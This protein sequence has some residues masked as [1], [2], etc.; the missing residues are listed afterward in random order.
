MHY[1][2][3][4]IHG[5]FYTLQKLLD[6]IRTKDS[7]PQLIFIGDY[8]DRGLH[9]KQV[10]DL[11]I[12]LQTEGAVCLRGNHDDVVDWL[13]NRKCTS[14]LAELMPPG[15]PLNLVTVGSWWLVNGLYP[16]ISSYLDVVS[17][18]PMDAI[19]HMFVSSVPAK[20]KAFFRKL[21]LYWEDETHFACHAYLDPKEVLPRTLAFLPSSKSMDLLWSRFPAAYTE[22]AYGRHI[23]SGLS[24]SKPVW[25]T[26]GIFGH[27]PVKCYGS[28]T[29]IKYG[30]LRLIDTGAFQDEYL[31][32]YTV[33]QDDHIL[34]ATDSRDI[35]PS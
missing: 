7:D 33:E 10:I 2:I 13:C 15:V 5:C 6:K 17:G 24:C 23:P 28:V 25:D 8:V 35:T 32:A 31:C 19:F 30:N 20:H 27:T 3:S 1:I 4:D 29:P 18:T 26:I 14:N 11:I 34:Q 9:S 12:E 16:A 21:R 22:T